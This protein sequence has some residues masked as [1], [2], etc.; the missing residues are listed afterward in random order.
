MEIDCSGAGKQ[1]QSGKDQQENYQAGPALSAGCGTPGTGG[2]NLRGIK[3]FHGFRYGWGFFCFRPGV[4]I[5]ILFGQRCISLSWPA[6]GLVL[7]NGAAMI[8]IYDTEYGNS[9]RF[10]IRNRIFTKTGKQDQESV[11]GCSFRSGIMMSV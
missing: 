8:S 1:N 2:I 5:I 3:Q 7:Q 11:P 4:Q 10:R 9:I 6:F